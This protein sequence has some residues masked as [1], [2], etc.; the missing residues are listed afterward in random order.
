MLHESLRTLDYHFGYTLVMLGCFIECGINHFHVRSLNGFLNIGNFLGTLIDQKNDHMH[1]GVGVF[2][3]FGHCL[4]KRGLTGFRRGYDHSSLSLTDGRHQVHDTHGDRCTG[5]IE[6][7]L[8][9]RE[10]RRH[11]FEIGSL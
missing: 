10:D 5:N 7:D 1:S 2:H 4:K 9:I 3:T 6:F 8:F 11:V